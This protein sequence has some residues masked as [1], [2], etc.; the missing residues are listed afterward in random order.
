MS[1]QITTVIQDK[2][3][4]WWAS[5]V[6]AFIQAFSAI[7]LDFFCTIIS[8]FLALGVS[9]LEFFEKESIGLGIDKNPLKKP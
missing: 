9:G 6:L 4:N 3:V 2:A 7:L 1:Q 8:K 5:T